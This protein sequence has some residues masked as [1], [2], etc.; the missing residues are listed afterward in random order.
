MVKGTVDFCM[1]KS[2]TALGVKAII[3]GT[4]EVQELGRVW[5]SQM[6]ILEP[7]R[8]LLLIAT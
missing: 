2:K 3:L 6:A 5:S 4:F 8:V 1:N 7:C